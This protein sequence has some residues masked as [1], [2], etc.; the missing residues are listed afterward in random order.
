MVSIL[1]VC[2]GR[3][4][5][6]FVKDILGE[7]LAVK[8]V[9]ANPITAQRGLGHKGGALREGMVRKILCN[10]LKEQKNRYV[11]TFFDLYG[12]PIKRFFDSEAI[13]Q[14]SSI[15]LVAKAMKS[16][17]NIHSGIVENVNCHP[18]RFIPYIQPCEFKSL[19][20]SQIEICANVNGDWTDESEQL[21]SFK[22]EFK[23]PELINDGRGTHPSA[24][25][26][27]HLPKYK[28]VIHGNSIVREIGLG[29]IRKE[30]SHFNRWIT[31]LESLTPL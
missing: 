21:P 24:V 20:F 14:N 29:Q 10:V 6:A 2:E 23:N 15:D 27:K 26:R 11:T 3:T 8:S 31:R 25:L 19:L 30:C 18:D 7:H 16:K 4:E 17:E 22:T 5:V 1:I 9:F 13:R 12:L 28:K